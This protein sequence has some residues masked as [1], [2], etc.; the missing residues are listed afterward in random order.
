MTNAV[1][2]ASA[3]GTG[4]LRNRIINGDMRIDQR[5]A[6]ASVTIGAS[7]SA[8]TLDRWALQTSVASKLS[9]QQNAGAVTPPVG[10]TNYLGV[11]S[12][13]SYTAGAAEYF[14]FVQ[15]I[16]GY[17]ISDLSWGTANAKTVTVSFWVYSSLTGNHTG[18]V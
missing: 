12:L 7:S 13:S 15:T 6:G 16:E 14:D 5:R 1:N 2:L 10:F 11:T 9:V 18:A 4:F 8:Y 3:A 17:N